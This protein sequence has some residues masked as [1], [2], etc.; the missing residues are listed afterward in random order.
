MFNRKSFS[1]KKVLEFF[2]EISAA[3]TGQESE[4][5]QN[6]L[7]ANPILEAFGNAKMPR[8]DDSSR[9]GKLFKAPPIPHHLC[10]GHLIPGFDLRIPNPWLA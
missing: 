7:I 2:A 3:K 4:V 5:A 9:F 6:I 1:A 8:N 10:I